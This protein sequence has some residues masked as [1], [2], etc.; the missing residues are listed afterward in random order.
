MRNISALSSVKHETASLQ[1]KSLGIKNIFLSGLT[2][3][4]QAKVSLWYNMGVNFEVV[5]MLAVKKI[6]ISTLKDELR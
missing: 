6:L 5:V 2:G 4:L 1:L 3:Q